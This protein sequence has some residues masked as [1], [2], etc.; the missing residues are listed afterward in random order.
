MLNR[1][2]LTRSAH[3]DAPLWI[4]AIIPVAYVVGVLLIMP[5][6][7]QFEFDTDEGFNVMKAVLVENGY[8]LYRDI[9]NDQPPLFTLLLSVIFRLFGSS[10]FAARFTVLLFSGLLIYCFHRLV[11]LSI[12]IIPAI[13]SSILLVSSYEFVRLSS[14]V[15]IGLPSLALALLSLVLMVQYQG[16]YKPRIHSLAKTGDR[17]H[18]SSIWLYAS[19]LCF[20]ASLHVKLVTIIL[21]PLYGLHILTPRLLGINPQPFEAIGSVLRGNLSALKTHPLIP[22]RVDVRRALTWL[23]WLG[24]PFVILGVGM[25]YFQVDQTLRTHLQSRQAIEEFERRSLSFSYLLDQTS[26][27]DWGIYALAGLGS[28]IAVVRRYRRALIPGI[29]LLIAVIVLIDHQPVWYHYSPLIMIPLCWL[30]AYSMMP[31]VRLLERVTATQPFEQPQTYPRRRLYYAVFALSIC[32]ALL[33]IATVASEGNRAIAALQPYKDN[34]GRSPQ[35]ELVQNMQANMRQAGP[36]SS[37]W[38]LTDA[39]IF[40]F[41]ANMLVPPEVV[42]FSKKRLLT[43]QLNSETILELMQAYAPHQI[44]FSRFAKEMMSQRSIVRYLRQHYRQ[45]SV[46]ANP[47]MEYF[48]RVPTRQ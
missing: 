11:R 22:T 6:W 12:G 34:L 24:I 17:P 3:L 7:T 39:P 28:T 27:Y 40:G 19:G 23:L 31:L 14:S 9:W 21:I 16:G 46:P 10:I 38:L 20:A 47:D 44:L 42:V 43:G 4:D 13:A 32:I 26:R 5:L 37:Q 48:V 15:M 18:H 45:E 33:S 29:W 41:Y 25:H 1:S 35:A 8:T 30:A 2:Q 36:E